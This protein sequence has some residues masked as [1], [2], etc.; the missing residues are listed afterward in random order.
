L[1]QKV[2]DAL[3]RLAALI[4]HALGHIREGFG[5]GLGDVAIGAFWLKTRRVGED[6]A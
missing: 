6:A 5:S 1:R 2:R 4:A 3:G